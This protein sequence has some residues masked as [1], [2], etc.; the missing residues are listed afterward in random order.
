MKRPNAVGKG[1]AIGV[2]WDDEERRRECRCGKREER[3]GEKRR[4]EEKKIEEGR[5]EDE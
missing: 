3:R 4:G 2:T 5:R 1:P